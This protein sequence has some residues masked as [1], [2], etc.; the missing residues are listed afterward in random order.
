MLTKIDNI[1]TNKK[2]AS[3]DENKKMIWQNEHLYYN[4]DSV[5]RNLFIRAIKNFEKNHGNLES[6]LG[7]NEELTQKLLKSPIIHHYLA[8]GISQVKF[9]NNGPELIDGEPENSDHYELKIYR[10]I[11]HIIPYRHD[12]MQEFYSWGVVQ[13]KLFNFLVSELSQSN[14]VVQ[15][16]KPMDIYNTAINL[17]L[18]R[19]EDIFSTKTSSKAS[20]F[21]IHLNWHEGHATSVISNFN[22]TNNEFLCS[23]FLNS[24]H[25]SSHFNS[26]KIRFLDQMEKT[27]LDRRDCDEDL[28]TSIK[29]YFETRFLLDV[30]NLDKFPQ[31]VV[32]EEEKEI[33]FID[34]YGS[35]PDYKNALKDPSID[36]VFRLFRDGLFRKSILID[37]NKKAHFLD[38]SHH[39]QAHEKDNN[40][41]LYSLFF[42][43]A[44]IEMLQDPNIADNIIQLALN[45][46]DGTKTNTEVEKELVYYFQEQ[47][48]SY[49]P[50]FYQKNNQAKS[51]LELRDFFIKSRWSLGCQGLT[52]YY[53]PEYTND[54]QLE[55][56]D[57]IEENSTLSISTEHLIQSSF[58]SKADEKAD[59]Y[60]LEEETNINSVE[61]NSSENNHS[62][63]WLVLF[64]EWLCENLSYLMHLI[65]CEEEDQETTEVGC[66]M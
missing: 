61:M 31:K 30:E 6:F 41:T 20:Q 18:M 65:C 11:P 53:P 10:L 26:M 48:K 52:L 51:E 59:L 56:E 19:I 8:R 13:L 64:I 43:K 28:L 27:S 36:R 55:F 63:N 46:N 9:G 45:L 5:S 40:C 57:R 58:F 25:N 3:N 62:M 39:L 35:L 4:A 34:V 33:C 38:V 17:Q 49:L 32:N 7:K 23:L 15:V 24:W 29:N 37:F 22:P 12:R 42:T 21:V 54:L 60:P 16:K 1:V 2:N 47:L 66:C 50:C 14:P 44:I